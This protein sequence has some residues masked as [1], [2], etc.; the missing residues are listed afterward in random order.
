MPKTTAAASQWRRLRVPGF[1][2]VVRLTVCSN[3]LVIPAGRMVKDSVCAD[4]GPASWSRASNT[5]ITIENRQ[6]EG[7][8]TNTASL[9]DGSGVYAIL[10]HRSDGKYYL[11]DCGES[12]TVKTRVENHDRKPCWNRHSF[13]TLNVAVFYTPSLQQS[14]RMAVEQAIRKALNPTCGDR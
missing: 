12:A 13:G 2:K 5:M 4:S 6:F 10:D 7:P 11:L 14:G 8:Y 1:P 3:R 9:Q